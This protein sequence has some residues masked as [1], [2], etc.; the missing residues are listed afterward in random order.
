MKDSLA[1][2]QGI[3][4]EIAKRS[5]QYLFMAA[6]NGSVA[7]MSKYAR[8]P[9]VDSSKSA[10]YAD[11]I[12]QYRD[13][14][15]RFLNQAVKG[16]DV[17]A[18]YVSWY[19]ADTGQSMLGKGVF[20]KE[21]VQRRCLRSCC[22]TAS[23]WRA[24]AANYYLSQ[25]IES[26]HGFEAIR[27]SSCKKAKNCGTNTL[28]NPFH[29]PVKKMTAPWTHRFARSEYEGRCRV[30]IYNMGF[31]ILVAGGT[32]QVGSALVR[33]LLAANSCTEV[34][35]VNR[36]TTP[37]VADAR[38]RQLIMD[39]S[40]ANFAGEIAEVA[41]KL[42]AHGE[43][44]VCRIMYRHRQRQPAME[45]RGHQEAGDRRGRR[46]CAWL[47]RGGNRTIRTSFSSRE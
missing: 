45:R 7:A 19:G 10:E 40:A 47:P 16:G 35:M 32:G 33:A 6:Q 27:S 22:T 15:A 1:A 36:R 43:P 2:C 12:I 3:S 39:T 38:L 24:A 25:D 31:R 41:R 29:R 8:D 20:Q 18:L 46:V 11:E 34:V 21:P 13:N 26:G 44:V 5:G 30:A 9:P 28:P 37:L 14:A 23:S 17:L 4:P 42:S